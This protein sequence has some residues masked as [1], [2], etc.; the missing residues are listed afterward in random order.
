[1][2][3]QA[4]KRRAPGRPKKA[5]TVANAQPAMPAVEPPVKTKKRTIKR[6][7]VVNENKEYKI[8]KGGGVVYMLPQKGVTVYDEA[9]DTVREIRY[10]PNEPSIYVDEQSDNAVRQ[11]V[12]FRMGRLFVPKEKPNLRKFLDMHPQNG[13]VFKEIDKRRDAEKELEKEFILT[14]AIARVRDADIN[15]LL[16]V[17]I[18]FGVNINAPV[19][20]IRY[21]L[22]TIAKRKTEEFLQSFD[23]PQVMTRSTI[24]Q[25]RDYQ[26]LN[27]KKNGVFWFD[28]NNLIVSVPVGQDPMDVMVRFCLTEKGASVLSN[29][30][31]RLDKLG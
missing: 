17:A 2:A 20:E 12:A 31:E 9:N 27:V 26:I 22:L 1:M 10:C 6:K 11:S 28:S 7:E 8:N 4:T 24:Q 14:D 3:E 21:N 19:S 16:P 13:P 29:L 23:S 5:E 25:A 15:D 30:E 18:Y